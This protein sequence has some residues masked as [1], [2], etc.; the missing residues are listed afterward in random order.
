MTEALFK[1][2]VSVSPKSRSVRLRVTVQHGLEVIVPRDYD[3]GRIPDLL[4]RKQHWINTALERAKSHRKF[5]EPLPAWRLPPQV[6]LPA[7][8]AVY[9]VAVNETEVPF[10]ATRELGDDRLLVTGCVHDESE[11]RAAL[12]RWLMRQTRRHLVPR[13]EALSR[14]TG[15]HYRRVFI[16]RQRTR[17]ASCS[18][19][20]TISLNSKLLFLPPELVAYVLTH[21]LC[22]VA[23]MNHSRRFWSLLA[24]HCPEFRKFDARLRDMWK[25]VPRW[26]ADRR[27]G[28]QR[29]SPDAG[30]LPCPAR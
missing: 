20:K 11:G 14:Q 25:A 21:E 27:V 8:G 7:I 30:A 6:R 12:A 17:W 24:Q 10:V 2:R 19:H 29:Y 18:R 23:E 16:K 26:A 9:H 5:F 3:E 28:G 1:Y 13:L 22:H 15:L 4:K